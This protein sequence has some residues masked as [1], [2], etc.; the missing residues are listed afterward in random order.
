MPIPHMTKVNT[1]NRCSYEYSIQHRIWISTILTLLINPRTTC[2]D[3]CSY[4]DCLLL[5]W[6]LSSYLSG[7][8]IEYPV[9]CWSLSWAWTCLLHL[10][11]NFGKAAKKSNSIIDKKEKWQ[12]WC[13]GTNR[14]DKWSTQQNTTEHS[15]TCYYL[16]HP[17]GGSFDQRFLVLCNTKIP[18]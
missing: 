15:T 10:F 14:N 1:Q 3:F 11:A 12:L 13:K 9:G 6:D 17:V 18:L 7:F 8:C 2:C 5:R 4:S 16:L